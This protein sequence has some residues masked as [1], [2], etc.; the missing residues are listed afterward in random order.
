MSAPGSSPFQPIYDAI[1]LGNFDA[2]LSQAD[3]AIANQPGSDEAHLL[4]GVALARLNRGTEAL[5]A[6]ATSISL[7]PNK[8]NAYVQMA[9]QLDQ[10]GRRDEAIRQA[11][12]ALRIDP[13]NH[14]ASRLL[15]AWKPME[16]SGAYQNPSAYPREAPSMAGGTL[17]F[18]NKM[19]DRKWMSIFWVV[20]AG[21]F[22]VSVFLVYFYFAS[23]STLLETANRESAVLPGPLMLT[24]VLSVPFSIGTI[25]WGVMDIVH[26]RTSW[27]WLIVFICCAP[28]LT[29]LYPTVGRNQSGR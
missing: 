20:Y 22:L 23:L 11:E 2:A 13:A 1:A 12:T 19:G 25:I 3:L 5:Q 17:E 9:W 14:E 16:H 15:N 7:N 29:W 6:L 18:I 10:L 4:K 27:A 26:K 21:Y 28:Y 24:G 8:P